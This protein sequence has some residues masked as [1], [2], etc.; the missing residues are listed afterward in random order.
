MS[1]P[2]SFVNWQRSRE[3]AG[4]R[5]ARKETI[6]AR[7]PGRG[8][9]KSALTPYQQSPSAN[10]S[11]GEKMKRRIL[12]ICI[13]L[14]LL[15][16]LLLAIT[17]QGSAQTLTPTTDPCASAIYTIFG[18]VYDAANPSLG[19]ANASVNTWTSIDA[20]P[21]TT[22]AAD[23]SYSLPI[24]NPYHG[25]NILG[26]VVSADGYQT[27]TQAINWQDLKAQPQRDFAMLRAGTPT[28][29]TPTPSPGASRTPTVTPVSTNNDVPGPDLIISSI[30][31]VGSNPACMNS[32]KDNVVV[33]NIGAVAAGTFV[34]AF[35]VN[36]TP[37]TPQ[38]VNGLGAGQSVTLSFDA[39]GN[40][41]ATADSTGVI[42]ETNE[43]NNSLTVV[44]LP[45]P[46][47]AHTCTPTGG[48]SLTPTRT[49][50]V[51]PTFTRTR[52]RTPTCACVTATPTRTPTITLTP[53]PG[54]VCSPVTGTITAPFTY[55]GAGTFCWQSTNL[56]TYINSWN[57][58]S[59]T[60]NGVNETN[61]YV[62]AA[63]CPARINGY[64]YVGYNSAVAYGHFEA[65]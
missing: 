13:L 1:I 22:T 17:S 38:T 41:T 62:A 21:M 39:A 60:V 36:G 56:G 46:T 12:S 23:G 15:M 26:L 7:K 58:T 33:S 40:V 30:T 32:P 54:G 19:I 63:S 35:S 45:V 47:Q 55:D 52:T 29:P 10:L 3:N 16:L 14:G 11:Q 44:N 25:C 49:P 24:T 31:Y 51:G 5:V 20:A 50:T 61:L 6:S 2:N 9:L 18:R 43:S 42:A 28:G 64:W 57:L 8:G 34:V 48:P 4:A 37:W 65:K 53:P 27:V 59:L